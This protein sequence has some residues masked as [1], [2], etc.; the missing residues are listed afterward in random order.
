MDRVRKL[1]AVLWAI[2]GLGLAVGLT[3]FAFGLGATTNLTDAVPWGFW[4]GFDVMSGV[5]LAAGGFTV[6]AIVYIFGLHK[7]HSIVRPAV[8]TAFLGYVAVV[9]GLLFDLGLPWNI[10]HMI[11]FWNPHSPLF[12]VGWCVMLYLTVLFLEFSPV[13]LESTSAFAK[14]R[15]FLVKMRIPLVITGIALSTLHQSSLGTLF[16]IMP[17]RVNPLWY[18]SILPILFFISAVGLGLMMAT[19]ESHFTAYFYRRKPE[20]DILAKLTSWSRWVLLTWVVVRI[21]DLAARGLGAEMFSLDGAML[22][23]W[24][25]LL[26]AGIIPII[27]FSLPANKVSH[28]WQWTAAGIG[29][30]GVVLNRINVGGFMHLDRGQ[31]YFPAWTEFAVSAGVVAFIALVFLFFIEKFNI[32]EERPRDPGEKPEALPE[33]DKASGATLGAPNVFGRYAYS[34]VF[35]LATAVGFA[36]LSNKVIRSEGVDPAPVAEARGGDTLWVDGNTDGYGV[37]FKHEQ[38][39]KWVAQTLAL[40]EMDVPPDSLA[41]AEAMERAGTVSEEAVCAACHHMNLPADETSGCYQCH[42]DMYSTTDAFR[43]DWHASPAG[44]ALA[45]AEC[46]TPGEVKNAESVEHNCEHCHKDL[47]PAQATLAVENY[48]APAYAAAMHDMCIGCHMEQAE[49]RNRAGLAQCA[50]CH[51]TM[52]QEF[53]DADLKSYER[54]LR[55]KGVILP[56]PQLEEN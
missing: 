25:E 23:F 33:F 31:A 40:A 11:I 41:L 10:W 34:M 5:A 12:E 48:G 3:R 6:T 8:L 44:A 32:W 27:M 56:M 51:G 55:G 53:V 22:W 47:V 18:S 19:F 38:H 37:F 45:C 2:V 43:H 26:L 35:V 28:Q 46:H 14:V 54:E 49:V 39:A 52:A 16:M 9:L 20:T 50:T 1:K 29:V 4:I 13:P 24:V 36:L 17:Y 42:A 15:R 30:F 7:F 21:V